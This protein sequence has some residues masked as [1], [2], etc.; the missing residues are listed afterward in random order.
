MPPTTPL[1][2]HYIAYRAFVRA[3]V[4]CLRHA[5]GDPSAGADVRAYTDLTVRHLRAGTVRLILVGGGPAT[6]KTTLAGGIADRLGAVV[7]SSD[8]VRK[9]MAGLSP[10]LSAA[11]ACQNGIYTREW[12]D[13]TYRELLLRAGDLLRRGETVVLDASWIAARH[14][15]AARQVAVETHSDLC[16]LRCTADRPTVVR[17]LA[18][19]T[20]SMSDADAAIADA[21]ADAA[22]PWPETAVMTANPSNTR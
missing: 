13:R 2:H 11:A 3:K 5:Q 9:E 8:R 21:M 18:H 7:L 10:G 16:Q 12:T 19:R 4:A 14:R 22:A 20:G 15:A 6:G 17:R 1:R